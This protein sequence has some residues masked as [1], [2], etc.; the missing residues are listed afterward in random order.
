MNQEQIAAQANVFIGLER[1]LEA[2]RREQR[3]LYDASLQADLNSPETTRW[4]TRGEQIND[5]VARINNT[6]LTILGKMTA[7]DSQSVH[8]I[9]N[10]EIKDFWYHI[11]N[12]LPP[13][14][15]R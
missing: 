7:E 10:E 4:M 13:E 2:L 1:E 8:R 12:A 14:A 11:P 6:K 5:Q 15:Q 3:I 9:V